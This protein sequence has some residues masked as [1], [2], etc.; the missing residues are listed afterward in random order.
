MKLSIK[1]HGF[2]EGAAFFKEA[3]RRVKTVVPQKLKAF[4][5]EAVARLKESIKHGELNLTP[6]ARP[7]GNPVLIHTGV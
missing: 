4:G 5:G 1:A 6:K 7:D 3:S 2:T